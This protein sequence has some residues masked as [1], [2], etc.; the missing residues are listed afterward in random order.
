PAVLNQALLDAAREGNVERGLELL[1][2]GADPA[3]LPA[4]GARDQRSALVLAA[5]L[6]DTRLLRALISRGAEVNRVHCEITALLAATRDSY[7]GRSDAVMTLLANGADPRMAD[8]DGNTPLHYAALAAEPSIAAI[9][10]DAQAPLD[11]LNRNRHSPLALAAGAA[12]WPLVK[13]LLEHGAK[14]EPAQ[15]VPALIAAASITDDD[16][17]GVQVLLKQKARVDALDA[18]GRSALMNA[19]LEGHARIVQALLDAGANAN[20]ADRRGVTALMEAAR[21]G[22]YPV[23]HELIAAQCDAR[24]R[25]EH[26]RDALV[27]A[28]QSPRANAQ[29]V[30]ALLAL[31]LDPKARSQDGRSALD[32]SAGAGR[33]DL[34]ALLDPTTPLPSSHAMAAQPEPG[35]DTPAHLLDALR[36]GHWAVASGFGARARGWPECELA[37]LYLDL[38]EGEHGAARRWLLEHGMD[39]EVRLDDGT[40]LFDALVDRLPASLGAL[41]Q[42]LEDG[43]APAGAGLFARALSRLAEADTATRPVQFALSLLERG[44]D[45]F[46]ADA[47]GRTPLHHA[48][49]AALAPVLHALL[50]RGVDPNARDRGGATPLHVALD[51]T[52]DSLQLV[53]TLVA[54]GAD[55]E[56]AAAN[57]ETPLGLAL[58]RGDTALEH[59]LRW[60]GWPLPRRPLR[61]EDLPAA[62]SAGDA[63]AVSK[64]LALGFDVNTRDKRGAGG[65]LRA[66]GAGH[67]EAAQR[68]I[69]AG[70]DLELAAESGATPLSAAISAR[71]ET[72]V[73]LLLDRGAKP[74]HRL[75]N[76][77]TALMVAA[78]LGFPEIVE[79][80]L[81]HGADAG[82]A[83]ASG[84]TAL[85]AAARF[86]FDSRDS[87]RCKRL[88]DAL[89]KARDVEVDAADKQGA[90]AL[91]LL[92]GAQSPPG[93]NADGTHL[94]ALVP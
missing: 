28:C 87:L 32:H 45:P 16:P 29:C 69:D 94:G 59:W 66:C 31:G 40:R 75:P 81:A 22:A 42:L 61:A 49:C 13:F 52:R 79:A 8:R 36:F 39:A 33:W 58:A 25:D 84:H 18:L 24:A 50:A 1:Q 26:G 88:L 53:R 46:G 70:A 76:E 62:A 72:V 77:A 38:A 5:L 73:A 67:A 30:R 3:A 14:C 82:L 80:L 6:P 74:D 7:H 15:G 20:L 54:F 65:L 12:N 60:H 10:I 43:A 51:A 85:H 86:C 90:S 63:E 37:A 27:L 56:R 41:G 21:A 17:Q 91:L 89:L 92:L 71:R 64:L 11:S 34:V 44:A 2:A 93:G 47:Q 55:P 83:D 19:A 4:P 68:L 57:G 35:A 48:A 78:A 23:L 9:L